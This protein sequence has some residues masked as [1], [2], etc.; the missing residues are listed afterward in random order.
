LT[1]QSNGQLKA[2]IERVERMHE[3]RKAIA[4]DISEIFKEAKGAGFNTAIIKKIVA[5]RAKDP[6]K[7]R[8]ERELYDLY[9]ASVGFE[10]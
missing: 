2:I 6:S 5:D 10:P 8:E 9:A 3:E 7:L 1:D 4:D